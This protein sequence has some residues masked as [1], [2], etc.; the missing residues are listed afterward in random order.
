M[1]MPESE[2]AA[3]MEFANVRKRRGDFR[4]ALQCLQKELSICRAHNYE[5][6]EKGCLVEIGKIY[7]ELEDFDNALATFGELKSK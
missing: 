7:I 3:W 5:D 2:R 6:D 4:R 1:R